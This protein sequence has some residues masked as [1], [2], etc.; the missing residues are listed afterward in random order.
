MA[1]ARVCVTPAETGAS[2]KL[3]LL[4]CAVGNK[5][6]SLDAG[7]PFVSLHPEMLGGS[8]SACKQSESPD[9]DTVAL[10]DA[11][12]SDTWWNLMPEL[13]LPDHA[14]SVDTNPASLWERAVLW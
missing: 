6:L 1:S 7:A 9:L 4:G 13:A 8:L 12:S 3:T 2:M 11:Q 10:P 14:T 5:V